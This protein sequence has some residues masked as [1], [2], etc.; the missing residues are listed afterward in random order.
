LKII[1]KKPTNYRNQN[2]QAQGP[3]THRKN[4]EK[5]HKI[6]FIVKRIKIKINNKKSQ[7]HK[8]QSQQSSQQMLTIRGKP[9]NTTKEEKGKIKTY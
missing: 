3:L 9:P 7:N 4:Q 8:L 6:K 2:R 1:I 5:H